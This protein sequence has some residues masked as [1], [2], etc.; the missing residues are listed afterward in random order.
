MAETTTIGAINRALA[1]AMRGDERV[2]VLGEDVAELSLI[3]I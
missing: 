2:I 3:H 1:E